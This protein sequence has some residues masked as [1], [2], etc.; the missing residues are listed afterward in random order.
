MSASVR[1]SHNQALTFDPLQPN[2]T[3][4]TGRVLLSVEGTPGRVEN[5]VL[6]PVDMIPAVIASLQLAAHQAGGTA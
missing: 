5:L 1:L 2:N 3:H 4:R 6:I